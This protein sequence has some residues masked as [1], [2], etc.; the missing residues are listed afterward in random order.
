MA[1]S[2]IQLYEFWESMQD[3]PAAVQVI[4]N[5]LML[6]ARVLKDLS[7]EVDLSP[8]VTFTLDACKVKVDVSLQIPI[9][10]YSFVSRIDINDDNRN[11]R[12]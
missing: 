6:L 9:P 5:D 3:A 1:Q 10:S 4:K 2:C 11:S 8:A 7:V 12:R